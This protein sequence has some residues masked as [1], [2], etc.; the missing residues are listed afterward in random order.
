MAGVIAVTLT[1]KDYKTHGVSRGRSIPAMME[2]A[3]HSL[4]AVVQDV[5][6]KLPSRRMR[7]H[8]KVFIGQTAKGAS[9]HLRIGEGVPFT[10]VQAKWG[11]TPTVIRP[12]HGKYLAI[13]LTSFGKSLQNKIGTS[14]MEWGDDLHPHWVGGER[15]HGLYWKDSPIKHFYLAHSVR[16]KPSVNLYD[17]REEMRITANAAIRASFDGYDFGF[18]RMQKG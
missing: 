13:P 10:N 9:A 16:V 18:V 2:N 17:V 12:K 15:G 1:R 14:L 8:T 11:T 4:N 6:A 3:L 7:A 5:K